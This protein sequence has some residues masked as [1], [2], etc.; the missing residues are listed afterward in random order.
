M[1]FGIQL[2]DSPK[3]LHLTNN[4]LPN[5]PYGGKMGRFARAAKLWKQHKGAISKPKPSTLPK[6]K[7]PKKPSVSMDPDEMN[8]LSLTEINLNPIVFR[9]FGDDVSTAVSITND[10]VCVMIIVAA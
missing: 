7:I 8:L 5:V 10:F 6:K 3:G 9:I 4:I 2:G 1:V